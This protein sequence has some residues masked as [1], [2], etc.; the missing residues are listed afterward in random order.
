[1]W[2][3]LVVKRRRY[4]TSVNQAVLILCALPDMA[5]GE[6]NSNDNRSDQSK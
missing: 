1:M 3:F 6:L 5:I 4:T 2:L